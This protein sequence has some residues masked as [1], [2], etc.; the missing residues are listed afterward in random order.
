M[1]LRNSLEVEAG[2]CPTRPTMRKRMLLKGL[3]F[4]QRFHVRLAAGFDEQDCYPRLDCHFWHRAQITIKPAEPYLICALPNGHKRFC[5]LKGSFIW[6]IQI[7]PEG[8]KA[9]PK[10][11]LPLE[12]AGPNTQVHVIS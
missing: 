2:T 10:R 11:G 5:S 9:P 6:Y 1:A 7:C 3:R 12:V 8:G 4:R